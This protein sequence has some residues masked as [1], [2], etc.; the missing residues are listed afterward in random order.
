MTPEE[1][2]ALRAPDACP[3][4]DALPALS[5]TGQRPPPKCDPPVP[6]VP[7][8]F[9]APAATPAPVI[10]PGY[11]VPEILV[12]N[13]EQTANCPAAPAA[14]HGAASIVAAATFTEAVA[15]LDIPA[16]TDTQ[17]R[18]LASID[19]SGWLGFTADQMAT[20]G[21]LLPSQALGV[22]N[23][24]AAA[25]SLANSKALALATTL[26]DCRWQNT[27]QTANCDPSGAATSAVDYPSTGNPVTALAGT[28]S[29]ATS[30]AD[31]DAQ[32]LAAATRAL[33]CV[34]WN[35]GVSATCAGSVPGTRAGVPG[36]TNDG[37]QM[38]AVTV[39]ANLFSSAAGP[40][41]A[42]AAAQAL[43]D[44]LLNCFWW[45]VE[46][47]RTCDDIGMTGA[48]GDDVTVAAQTL[49]STISQAD[50]DDQ[51]KALADSLLDCYWNSAAQD[52]ICPDQHTGVPTVVDGVDTWDSDHT[53]PA[54]PSASPSYEVT[55]PIGAVVS[56][57]S[58]TDADDQALL[59]AL[60]QLDCKYCNKQVHKRCAPSSPSDDPLV[61]GVH[62]AIGADWSR[63]VT[64]GVAEGVYCADTAST[65]Q[66]FADSLAG[67]PVRV[68]SAPSSSSLC[69]WGNNP[70]KARCIKDTANGISGKFDPEDTTTLGLDNLS[71][72]S[73]PDPS[74]ADAFVYVP[75]DTIIL[76]Q[77]AIDAADPTHAPHGASACQ[78]WVDAEAETLV[79]AMLNCF[80]VNED[81]TATCTADVKTPDGTGTVGKGLTGPMADSAASSVTTKAGVFTSFASQFEANIMAQELALQGLNCF[82]DNHQI[83]AKCSA[84]L[85]ADGSTTTYGDFTMPDGSTADP[86]SARS[87]VMLAHLFISYTSQADADGQALASAISQLDCWVKNLALTV[88]CGAA[89]GDVTTTGMTYGTGKI[90]DGRVGVADVDVAASS[91]GSA[92]SPVLVVSGL[93][94][95]R[96][97]MLE[98]QSQALAAG[99]AQLDCYVCSVYMIV[100]C[101]AT[102]AALTTPTPP[103]DIADIGCGAT[104]IAE[105]IACENMILGTPVAGSSPLNYTGGDF[106]L[107]DADVNGT[108]GEYTFG[109]GRMP[110]GTAPASCAR[111]AVAVESCKF[112]SYT[113]LLDANQMA[114]VEGIAELDCFAYNDARTGW[115]EGESER[116]VMKVSKATG[117]DTDG[118]TTYTTITSEL[119]RPTDKAYIYELN[120]DGS[121]GTTSAIVGKDCAANR[122][123]VP[124]NYTVYMVPGLQPDLP[125]P[126]PHLLPTDTTTYPWLL[127]Y[128]WYGSDP[129]IAVT[130]AGKIM[131]YQGKLDAN[132]QARLIAQA[133]TVCLYGNDR[134]VCDVCNSDVFVAT[135]TSNAAYLLSMNSSRTEANT[136]KAETRAQANKIALSLANAAR[137]CLANYGPLAV[138]LGQQRDG[139]SPDTGTGDLM[140]GVGQGKIRKLKCGSPDIDPTL[141]AGMLQD[142]PPADEGADP[143]W[144][145]AGF[146][147][148]FVCF[149]MNFTGGGPHATVEDITI[150]GTEILYGV[151]KDKTFG[152]PE[153]GTCYDN[154]WD[155]W[156][157]NNTTQSFV[158][159]PI[160]RISAVKDSSGVIT[161]HV[162]QIYTGELSLADCKNWDNKSRF[163][164][165]EILPGG[166]GATEPSCPFQIIVKNN[167]TH[168]SPVWQ[169][170]VLSGSLYKSANWE[171]RQTV[172]GLLDD[173]Q[174]TGWFDVILED[175]IWLEITWA[176]GT[177]S[178]T[179]HSWGQGDSW[180]DFAAMVV[181]ASDASP[182]QTKALFPIGFT[183]ASTAG[184]PTP[185]VTQSLCSDLLLANACFKGKACRYPKPYEV[186]PYL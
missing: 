92:S 126:L 66:A 38:G 33:V 121:T 116:K 49:Q 15:L 31:A 68:S 51:A 27:D 57:I 100:K 148:G 91:Y 177:M 62:G 102:A 168:S 46:E 37:A 86:G 167:G 35:D 30:Q 42:D 119:T 138:I 97:G 56:K 85:P 13:T 173:A 118:W 17:G 88:K 3:A 23:A 161:W 184:V 41:E 117:R 166:C 179:I 73:T 12:P 40:E 157:C 71:H 48:L 64:L 59:L 104:G 128:K 39:A 107:G 180:D 80:W 7:E 152:C 67:I 178:A 136:V 1:R 183:H 81:M 74:N 160:A 50:A 162:E 164:F 22:H 47:T 142:N 54:S 60:G 105:V 58:Q 10:L 19:T 87:V 174:T 52:V 8:V 75:K 43:A 153:T 149:K 25:L 90:A 112:K 125:H 151:T 140:V 129:V 122:H 65:A 141:K 9:V 154:P 111:S 96:A 181:F 144:R 98:C 115:C 45:N 145:T 156:C 182:A 123:L 89:L 93:F 29:S 120:P 131:S 175:C 63:D 113:S 101:G 34:W 79:V 106:S 124:P 18:H 137:D 55:L 53:Y 72:E 6:A 103:P 134:V 28:F 109:H 147:E 21:R 11:T 170:G 24:V 135:P 169:A 155:A 4:A 159:C 132:R 95:S 16:L 78:A 133:G 110:D 176:S 146:T 186:K 165:N 32:A 130:P 163:Y 158:Q 108:G 70:K 82:W 77:S 5:Q 94:K 61:L 127:W 84:T 76:T 83:T 171:D 14:S 143:H 99:I 2:A 69:T 185:E 139:E 36:D 44:S 150:T 26:L 172:T 20:A 114:L